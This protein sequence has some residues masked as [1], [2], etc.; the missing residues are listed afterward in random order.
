[1]PPR[2]YPHKSTGICQRGSATRPRCRVR[3]PCMGRRLDTSRSS[4]SLRAGR[5]ISRQAAGYRWPRPWTIPDFMGREPC[6]NPGRPRLPFLG[7]PSFHAEPVYHGCFANSMGWRRR[8]RTID[9]AMNAERF[10]TASPLQS[11]VDSPPRTGM[12][13][14]NFTSSL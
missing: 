11:R 1:M 8:I 3:W 2:R 10:L 7:L 12:N 4:S 5:R 14:K 6:C 9:V 13:T